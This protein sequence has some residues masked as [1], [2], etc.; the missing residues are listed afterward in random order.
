VGAS[1]K[2]GWA[3]GHCHVPQAGP[4][5]TMSPLASLLPPMRH[6]EPLARMYT[7]SAYAVEGWLEASAHPAPTY[8]L[9]LM[10]PDRVPCCLIM[11]IALHFYIAYCVSSSVAAEQSPSPIGTR[12]LFDP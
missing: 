12:A 1:G 4:N 9:K 2:T 3:P 5:R 11:V 8:A 7:G 10:Q 6:V